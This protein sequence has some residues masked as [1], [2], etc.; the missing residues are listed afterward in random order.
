AVRRRDVLILR[1]QISDIPVAVSVTI[2]L[3]NER[4]RLPS[5]KMGDRH[6]VNAAPQQSRCKAMPAAM[7]AKVLDLRA[8]DRSSPDAPQIATAVI[9]EHAA[10]R[11]LHLT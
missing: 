7:R 3:Q 11:D 9:T 1:Q 2:D 4:W 6:H 5:S 10:I 8:L